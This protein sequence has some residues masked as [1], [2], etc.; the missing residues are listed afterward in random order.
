MIIYHPLIKRWFP[1]GTS[2]T[3]L[4]EPIIE[5]NNEYFINISDYL[6][7]DKFAIFNGL[8]EIECSE[9]TDEKLLN[10]TS[11]SE[12]LTLLILLLKTSAIRYETDLN[13]VDIVSKYRSNLT[14]L[15]KLCKN[16]SENLKTQN[17]NYLEKINNAI[18]AF[19]NIEGVRQANDS[20]YNSDYTIDVVS[21]FETIS[22]LIETILIE[23]ENLDVDNVFENIETNLNTLNDNIMS[24]IVDSSASII[25]LNK[26]IDNYA[27][28]FEPED[29]YGKI[30]SEMLITAS[31]EMKKY[32]G[33]RDFSSWKYQFS[34][35]SA[36]GIFG[37]GQLYI[38]QEVGLNS[39]GYTITN[40]D[41][42]SMASKDL[43]NDSIRRAYKKNLFAAQENIENILTLEE[44]LSDEYNLEISNKPQNEFLPAAL[45][46]EIPELSILNK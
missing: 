3:I 26:Y 17:S 38:A 42:I 15:K 8:G 18:S 45:T 31:T 20:N 7:D 37:T 33:I 34:R 11:L 2:I 10:S 1:Y 25:K 12:D 16:F 4:D 44:T 32:F 46:T 14:E 21:G 36:D 22:G 30:F 29:N 24:I 39:I 6:Y 23:D 43:V 5:K 27:V 35:F 9:I 19:D 13:S 41:K 40:N 28:F